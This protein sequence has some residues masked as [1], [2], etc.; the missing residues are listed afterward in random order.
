MG[1]LRFVHTRLYVEIQEEIKA[2]L[3][4]YTRAQV[5]SW[6]SGNMNDEAANDDDVDADK[7][8]SEGEGLLVGVVGSE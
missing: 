1:S 6:R 4:D 5:S 8:E 2:M 3:V 7:P